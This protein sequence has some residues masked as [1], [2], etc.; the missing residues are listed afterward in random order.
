MNAD[1]MKQDPIQQILCT[2]ANRS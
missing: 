1:D 2:Q